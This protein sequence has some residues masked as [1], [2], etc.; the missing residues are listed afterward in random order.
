MGYGKNLKKALAGRK[1]SIGELARKTGIHADTIQQFI[2]REKPVTLNE[3]ILMAQ[4]LAI[5]PALICREARIL[6]G[7]EGREEERKEKQIEEQKEKRIE[8]QIAKQNE[9]QKRIDGQIAERDKDRQEE[10]KE[11]FIR[12]FPSSSQPMRSER[13]I[14]LRNMMLLVLMMHDEDLEMIAQL[15]L[16]YDQLGMEERKYILRMAHALAAAS[17]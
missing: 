9:E 10:R 13:R 11:G 16:C 2:Q 17:F 1:M 4:A 5:E 14:Q 6:A 12:L 3:A 7:E 15:L 8:G